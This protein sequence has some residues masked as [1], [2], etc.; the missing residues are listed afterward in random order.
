MRDIAVIIV[1]RVLISTLI[2]SYF[3]NLFSCRV[4]FISIYIWAVFIE[5][6]APFNHCW[7]FANKEQKKFVIHWKTGLRT[8]IASCFGKGFYSIKSRR[9]ICIIRCRNWIKNY[10]WKPFYNRRPISYV[11]GKYQL[12]A[13]HKSG[14]GRR[15]RSRGI[16]SLLLSCQNNVRVSGNCKNFQFLSY[17]SGAVN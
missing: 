1:Y 13:N 10:R 12:Q 4:R 8:K 2:I 15:V 9:F 3:F 11:Y 5:L 16:T 17:T 6:N 7:V 14:D